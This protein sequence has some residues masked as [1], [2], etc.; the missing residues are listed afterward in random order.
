MSGMTFKRTGD[1]D[2]P[3]WLKIVVQGA[4]KSGKTTFLSTFPNVLIADLEH[5][6]GG[7]M[8]IA[9]KNVPYVEIDSS[10]RLRT[11]RMIL[12]D[13]TMRAKAAAQMGME[14]IET[15]AIDTT[16]EL[17]RLLKKERM[18]KTRSSDF[19]RDDWGWLLE[20]M[21]GVIN[22][23]VALPLHVVFTVHTKIQQVDEDHSINAPALQGAIADELPGMV[24]FA[25]E[26]VKRKQVDQQGNSYTQYLLQ[27]EGD[28]SSPHL[29]NRAAGKLG[30]LIEPTF[31]TIYKAVFSNIELAK[32]QQTEFNAAKEADQ[33]SAQPS[34]DE[35]PDQGSAQPE[36]QV[37][38]ENEQA[39]EEAPVA[40]PEQVEP[41]VTAPT[42]TGTPPADDTSSPIT[43]GALQHLKKMYEEFGF[44]LPPNAGEWTLGK[45][46]EIA[47]WFVAC[48][49]DAAEG[50]IKGEE[51]EREVREGLQGMDAWVDPDS[52][53]VAETP[54]N[55]PDVDNP[56]YKNT[57]E[58]VLS[59]VGSSEERAR[60]A[61]TIEQAN[62]GRS[63][64]VNPLEDLLG[65]KKEEEE[66]PAPTPAVEADQPEESSTDVRQNDE[67]EAES[68][69]GP[70]EPASTTDETTDT[71]A[72]DAEAPQDAEA[73]ET[74]T[75]EEVTTL[76]KDELGGT[77]VAPEDLPE[78]ERP[79]AECGKVADDV[80][81]AKLAKSRFGS[82]LCVDD[83][84]ARTKSA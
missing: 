10:E 18:E 17:Q 48:K 20:E 77:E 3:Q 55:H 11:L 13:D 69:E 37:V 63:T 25:L 46:R 32:T 56:K 35:V 82:W 8:S 5:A 57:V 65:I 28:E 83:Y 15:V 40:A 70:V 21:R 66:T 6:Q 81:I 54:P 12:S 44:V 78:A 36:T 22:A 39:S 71:A 31:E 73:E 34:S 43:K 38:Q 84:I 75:M 74:L 45:G 41:K 67:N 53:E 4:P 30:K 26:T 79:C 68:A 61:L 16:D 60:A 58:D 24:A 14:K 23:F 27:A 19:K 62:K 42:D 51:V 1:S 59:W 76:V 72:T 64:L 50:K 47:R 9:H 33:G 29:G 2:Y 52:E 7:L 49:S 80:D